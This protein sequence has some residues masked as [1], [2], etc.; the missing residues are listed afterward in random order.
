M[1]RRPY[2]TL[3]IPFFLKKNVLITDYYPPLGEVKAP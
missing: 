3:F 1:K 2:W